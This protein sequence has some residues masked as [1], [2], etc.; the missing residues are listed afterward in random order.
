[1]M[2]LDIQDLDLAFG[3]GDDAVRILTGVSLVVDKAGHLVGALHLHDLM[4]AKVI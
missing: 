4:T 3:E 2:L 1:M